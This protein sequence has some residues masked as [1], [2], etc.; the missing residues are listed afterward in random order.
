MTTTKFATQSTK[1][2]TRS[3]VHY[4][5]EVKEDNKKIDLQ[6]IDKTARKKRQKD[7]CQSLDLLVKYGSDKKVA[8]MIQFWKKM[9]N[10][11]MVKSG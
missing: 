11:K 6:T 8:K 7:N 10:K 9:E 2:A 1:I 5:Q 3:I 4:C